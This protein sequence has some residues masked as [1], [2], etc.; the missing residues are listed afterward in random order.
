MSAKVMIL[1]GSDSDLPVMT[2]TAKVL[3]KLGIGFDLHVSSAHRTPARTAKLVTD[4]VESGV[5]VF[6]CGAGAAAHLAGFVAAHTTRPVIGVPLVAGDLNGF[7]ALLAT[8]QMPP[9]IPVATVAVG[10]MG[11]MN[12]GWLAASILATADPSLE[13]RLQQ[14]REAMAEKVIEKS[15]RARANLDPQPAR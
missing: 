9:G 2:E 8:V 13:T 5:G 3:D 6:V 7:D 14:E 11:A 1:M 12:A 4:A 15:E 10:K